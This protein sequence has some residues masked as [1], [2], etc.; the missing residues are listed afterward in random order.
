MMSRSSRTLSLLI[1]IKH[2][3]GLEYV[4]DMAGCC[5]DPGR[6]VGSVQALEWANTRLTNK[7]E[8]NSTQTYEPQL[9]SLDARVREHFV[10]SL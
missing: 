10:T 7:Q 9:R 3:P 6:W 4:N 1:N 5:V 2:H 8:P